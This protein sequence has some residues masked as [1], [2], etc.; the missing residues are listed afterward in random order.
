MRQVVGLHAFLP[1]QV[2]SRVSL[3][4]SRQAARVCDQLASLFS[5]ETLLPDPSLF[6]L[7]LPWIPRMPFQMEAETRANIPP[8][9]SLK[10]L[11]LTLA[12]KSTAIRSKNYLHLTG[13]TLIR[14]SEYHRYSTQHFLKMPGDPAKYHQFS[15]LARMFPKQHCAID[16]RHPHKRRHVK[17]VS[18]VAPLNSSMEGT[19]KLSRLRPVASQASLDVETNGIVTKK[20]FAED[21]EVDLAVGLQNSKVVDLPSIVAVRRLPVNP[22]SD[23][24]FRL[25]SRQLPLVIRLN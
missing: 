1:N 25:I 20:H 7:H 22:S 9:T 24:P 15:R 19:R 17:Q 10:V 16:I 14:P 23:T 13:H 11:R 21:L 12:V 8:S 18:T 3:R 6:V 5:L 2:P 4:Y